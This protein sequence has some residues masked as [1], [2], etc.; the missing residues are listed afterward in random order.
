VDKTWHPVAR[1]TPGQKEELR[2]SKQAKRGVA[3][4]GLK[5]ETQALLMEAIQNR[6][7]MYS[8]VYVPDCAW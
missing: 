2:R 1:V 7:E 6:T 4:Q 5:R 8:E 3:R